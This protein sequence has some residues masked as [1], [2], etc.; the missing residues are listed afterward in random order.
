MFK[1]SIMAITAAATLAGCS[2]T[3][4]EEVRNDQRNLEEQRRDVASAMRDGTANEVREEQADVLKAEKKLSEA[5]S[6]LYAP[7]AEAAALNVGDR[8]SGNLSAL[9]D[10]NQRGN[11]RTM[12]DSY[13]RS[14]GRR[15]YR[16]GKTDRIV[17][18]TYPI[19]P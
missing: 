8:D 17:T 2:T 12:L 9:P 1:L 16:I 6:E 3:Q 11:T 14:D 13:Y 19:V 10:E 4:R 15:I 18:A 7:G 5:R